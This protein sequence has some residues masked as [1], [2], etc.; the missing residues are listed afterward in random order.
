MI[1]L[2]VHLLFRLEVSIYS[3]YGDHEHLEDLITYLA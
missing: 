1:Y 3:V 2:L